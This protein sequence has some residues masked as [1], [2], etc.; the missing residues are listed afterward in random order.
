MERPEPDELGRSLVCRPFPDVSGPGD[1]TAVPAEASF[2]VYP[3]QTLSWW[4]ITGIDVVPSTPLNAVVAFGSST[5]EGFGSTPNANRR[6][7]DYLARRLRDAVETRFMSVLNAGI[8][9]NQLTSSETPLAGGMPPFLFGEAGSTRL[10]WDALTQPGAT[11]LILH[12]GSNDLRVGVPGAT[13]IEALQHVASQARHT[14]R[15]VFGT[16][17]LPGGYPPTQVEQRSLV[18][19]W[20]QE[21]GRQWFDAIFDLATP[22]A[23]SDDEAVLH[24]ACDSGD[25]IHPDDEGYRRMAEAIE[26]NALTGTPSRAEPWKP[27]ALISS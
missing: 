6:W 1:V 17:I 21:Q 5:T 16:T 26:I 3:L 10:A 18:N 19:T 8:G 25:G 13:V 20:L 15:R 23:S 22:L 24:P 9:G 2:F 14:Y 7:P 27:R 11:D 4:L 12:I